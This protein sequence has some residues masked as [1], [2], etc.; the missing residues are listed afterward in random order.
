VSVDNVAVSFDL[1]IDLTTKIMRW[2][3]RDEMTNRAHQSRTAPLLVVFLEKY[4]RAARLSRFISIA[5]RFVGNIFNTECIPRKNNG[6]DVFR[7]VSLLNYCVV[8]VISNCFA[9]FLESLIY[10]W[11][12]SAPFKDLECEYISILFLPYLKNADILFSHFLRLSFNNI[13]IV[14]FFLQKLQKIFCFLLI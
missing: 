9:S 12:N 4:K 8:K 7:I 5:S 6:D 3:T 10:A 11:Y 14:I 1:C 2:L 13:Y